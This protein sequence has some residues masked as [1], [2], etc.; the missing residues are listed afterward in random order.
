MAGKLE[1]LREINETLTNLLIQMETH[2]FVENIS[3]EE[4]RE[5]IKEEKPVIIVEPNQ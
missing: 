1:K 2:M 5:K 4:V 3:V